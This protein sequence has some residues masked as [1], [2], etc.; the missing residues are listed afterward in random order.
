V[1]VCGGTVQSNV[2][3]EPGNRMPPADARWCADPLVWGAKVQISVGLI[4]DFITVSKGG[5]HDNGMPSHT[6][7]D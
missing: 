2:A 4:N 5:G 3:S 6:T 1:C 7:S